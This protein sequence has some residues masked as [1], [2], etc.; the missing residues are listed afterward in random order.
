MRNFIS[1]RA[2]G[3]NISTLRR[4]ITASNRDVSFLTGRR[5]KREIYE[6]SVKHLSP[7]QE[8]PLPPHTHT[9]TNT[10]GFQHSGKKILAVTQ[11][12]A[13]HSGLRSSG[14]RL[15]KTIHQF[16]GADSDR[17]ESICPIWPASASGAGASCLAGELSG[18]RCLAPFS[19]LSP[20]PKGLATALFCFSPRPVCHGSCRHHV[21]RPEASAI[22]ETSQ[23]CGIGRK[24]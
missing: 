15:A 10:G 16:Y 3:R 6:A 9:H 11:T 14:V 18:L 19:P 4:L 8:P 5:T 20:A 12:A 21:V 17:N 22:R 24:N 23:D 13:K 7:S 2:L 1:D